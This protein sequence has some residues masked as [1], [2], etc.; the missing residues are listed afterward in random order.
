MGYHTGAGGTTLHGPIWGTPEKRAHI[1]K[2]CPEM[3]MALKMDAAKYVP[4]KCHSNWKRKETIVE[5]DDDGVVI[6]LSPAPGL[7]E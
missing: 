7:E 1:W 2:Y 6:G 4:G 5:Q 3:K